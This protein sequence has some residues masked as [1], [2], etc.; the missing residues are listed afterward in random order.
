MI[1]N[2]FLQCSILKRASRSLAKTGLFFSLFWCLFPLRLFGSFFE[3]PGGCFGLL[4]LH[5]GLILGCLWC[6]FDDFW[7]ISGI[8]E[9]FSF[10]IVKP[11]FLR[12]G[13]VPVRHF[14]V[15]LFRSCF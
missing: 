12:F 15:S 8:Y 1:E 7:M 3:G 10:T 4:W 9:N 5:F 11:Y 2:M 6:H 14:L 13:E